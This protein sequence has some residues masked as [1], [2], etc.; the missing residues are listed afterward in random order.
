[1]DS[2]RSLLNKFNKTITSWKGFN[3][4]AFIVIALK[5]YILIKTLNKLN[6]L[7]INLLVNN[8]HKKPP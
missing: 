4:I 6:L 7:K 3:F 2:F 1:M 5:K 8:K